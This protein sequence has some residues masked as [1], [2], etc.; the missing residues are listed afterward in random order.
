MFG[1]QATYELFKGLESW[2]H[3]Y[4]IGDNSNIDLY[5]HSRHI[6]GGQLT[7]RY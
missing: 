5:N 7:Y 3:R 4:F 1:R 2:I 6:A